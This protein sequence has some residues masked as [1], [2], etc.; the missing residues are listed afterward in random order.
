MNIAAD[1][2]HARLRWGVYWILIAVGTGA[3]LGRV[4]A[5]DSVDRVA[6]EQDRLK[7]IE[8]T[9]K[10]KRQQF[11]K[12]G[13][14]PEAIEEK[15]A[16]IEEGLY[17]S[18]KQTRPFLS[19]NDRSRW[20]T[21][22]ALV[23]DDLRVE[24]YPFSIDKVIQEP[25]WDTIDMVKHDGHVFSSKPPLYPVMM[26]GVYWAIYKT[27]GMTL[28]THPYVVGRM[29]LVLFNVLPMAFF[30]YVI[31]RLVERF[32]ATDWS[33]I[34]VMATA[35]F[36]TFLT[37]FAIVVNNHVTAA[38]SAAIAIYAAARILCD[39]Q[40]KP[41]YF[42]LAGVFAAF[43]M[44][45]ELPAGA[46]FVALSG[47]LLW[48]APWRTLAV[49]TPAAAVVM[50]AFFATNWIAHESLK[51]PYMHRSEGDD[52]YDYTYERNGRVI[53]SYWRNPAGVDRGEPSAATY[54]V[55][56]L[57]GH[58]GIFSLTP[59]WIISFAGMLMWILQRENRQLRELGVLIA[60]VTLICL[61]FYLT[62]PLHFRNYGGVTCG[63]RWMFWFAPLWL[64]TML[65][66]CDL[67]ARRRW[68]QAVGLLALML[69]V[70]SV[71]YPT[72]N[73]WVHPWLMYFFSYMGWLG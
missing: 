18:A 56:V 13:L 69:S 19:A 38:V 2:P 36:G 14:A 16:E 30:F 68:T 41:R 31:A 60:A 40:Q 9:L 33:R 26:A 17:R 37:T 50:A 55:H 66:G 53:E 39:G 73:P 7:R 5:V 46:F 49:Y 22:R 59:V 65:P 20:C 72:W 54:A 70:L 42:I 21:L 3:L 10:K 11:E 47:L 62:R 15:L 45:N 61:A 25:G 52:W 28:G 35:V 48:K 64:L 71:S 4:G 23:E 43:T 12:Q 8:P 58:H 6:L 1:G 34:F 32:A 29:M 24:G 27:T 57:V 63:L 67:L 44:A 51:P